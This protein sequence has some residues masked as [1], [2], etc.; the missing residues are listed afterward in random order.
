MNKT[1]VLKKKY[2]ADEGG[3][4]LLYSVIF[5]IT[6]KSQFFQAL[7]VKIIRFRLEKVCSCFDCLLLQ[8]F[9]SFL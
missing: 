5:L 4:V 1:S 8:Y 9:R 7:T 3:R 6:K 2:S